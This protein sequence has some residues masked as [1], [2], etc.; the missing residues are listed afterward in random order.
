MGTIRFVAAVTFIATVT[1]ILA[2]IIDPAFAQVPSRPGVVRGAPGPIVGAGLT[3][4]VITAG[5][6]W[7]YRRFRKTN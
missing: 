5:A 2:P 3:T 6:Y 7:L 1:G 4:V